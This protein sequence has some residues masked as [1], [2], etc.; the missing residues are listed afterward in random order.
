ML[1]SLKNNS[2][3]DNQRIGLAV[4]GGIDSMVLL[5]IFRRLSKK[6]NIDLYVLHFNHKWRE[7]SYLD[8]ELVLNYCKKYQIKFIY[9]EAKGT[10]NKTE[11]E[12][13]KLRY[14]FFDKVRAKYKL[15][16]VCTAH[17]KDDQIETI[18]FRLLRGTGPKGLSPIKEFDN[19]HLLLLYRP[20][21]NISKDEI[22]SY[23]KKH[24]IAYIDDIT[25]KD[26]KYKRNL[27]RL[28]I[29][30][31]MRKINPCAENNL[32]VCSDLIYSQDQAVSS[33]FAFILKKVST[34]S[35]FNWDRFRF[36]K[37]DEYTQKAFIYWFFSVYK[38][39]G[40]VNKIRF[41]IDAIK[42]QKRI[43]LNKNLSLKVDKN[44]I[45]FEVQEG[46]VGDA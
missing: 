23:A 2:F 41:I 38:F 33:Y 5:D 39:K 6:K 36:L 30:P 17:H 25:N 46:R 11:E 44:A 10:I 28:K 22:N 27:I 3:F 1:Q 37:L 45:L 20:F 43:D 15:K 42:M 7:K 14:S 21:I 9:D 35:P 12:A 34:K 4:S 26:L 29:L 18:I 19:L 13:R 16:A 8:K 32:L 24:H 40:S 31:L